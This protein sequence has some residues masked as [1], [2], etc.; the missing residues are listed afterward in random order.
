M[1]CRSGADGGELGPDPT[2]GFEQA[3]VVL[4]AISRN[5]GTKARADEVLRFTTFCDL[6][7]I[8]FYLF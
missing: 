5:A 1:P 3:L 6:Y 2:V 4:P 8:M 7:K